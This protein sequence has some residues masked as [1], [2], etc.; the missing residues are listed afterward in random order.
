VVRR[1]NPVHHDGRRA[2]GD[3]PL[4]RRWDVWR[5]RGDA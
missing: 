5:S 2:A 3:V 1:Q 4:R